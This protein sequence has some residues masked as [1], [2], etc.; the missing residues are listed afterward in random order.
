MFRAATA[1]AFCIAS[2]VAWANSDPLTGLVAEPGGA[3]L[4]REM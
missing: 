3:G 2:N 1:I 4:G